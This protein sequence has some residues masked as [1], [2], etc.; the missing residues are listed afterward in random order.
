MTKPTI[1]EA[2][3]EIVTKFIEA[4]DIKKA[5]EQEFSRISEALNK[6]LA[7]EGSTKI[8][9]IIEVHQWRFNANPDQKIMVDK[10]FIKIDDWTDTIEIVARGR[11][12]K[13][14]GT[15]GVRESRN[16]LTIDRKD[17]T[18]GR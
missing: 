5:A 13:A 11:I 10:I 17:L 15:P 4:A 14:D 2:M 8:G 18:D 6:R 9:D 1:N 3:K 7:D 16:V 12:I